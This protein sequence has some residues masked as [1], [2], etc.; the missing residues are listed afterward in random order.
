MR[1]SVASVSRHYSDA[2]AVP[3]S[4]AQVKISARTQ[5]EPCTV[6]A[7]PSLRFRA[8]VKLWSNITRAHHASRSKS[9]ASQSLCQRSKVYHRCTT[10]CLLGQHRWHTGRITRYSCGG[11][12]RP[13]PSLNHRTPNGGLS[14]PGLAVRG[15]FS[16]A[17]AKPSRRRWPVSSNVRPQKTA[18]PWAFCAFWPPVTVHQTQERDFL[19]RPSENTTSGRGRCV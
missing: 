11:R 6:I 12:L 15:T 8:S 13:N 18:T 4:E 16:P 19:W 3:N 14:W 9:L 5:W 10:T 7:S 1:L 2:E 17:R